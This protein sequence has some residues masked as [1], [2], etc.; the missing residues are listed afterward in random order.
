MK[1]LLHLLVVLMMG[2][3]YAQSNL[4]ACQ[5]SDVSKWTNCFGTETFTDSSKYVGD[6]KNGK[7]N[8]Q[9]THTY[10]DGSK[11]V[12]NWKDDKKHGRGTLTFSD[13]D[14]YVGNWKDGNRNGRGTLTY[15]NGNKYV[16]NWK[17]DNRNGRGTE[18]YA[19]GTKYV[20]NWKDDKKHGRGTLTFA[21][22]NKYIGE[23]KDDE[24][25]GQGTITIFD[26]DKYIGEFKDG[27]RYG[28]GTVIFA[29]GDKYFEDINDIP[30]NAISQLYG[31]KTD[32]DKDV[33]LQYEEAIN[34]F[35]E[36]RLEI[37]S[38]KGFNILLKSYKPFLFVINHKNPE[39][40]AISDAWYRKTIIAR[41]SGN[42][43]SGVSVK[44]IN[45]YLSLNGRDSTWCYANALT[46][47]S[48]TSIE[49]SI[50]SEID[51]DMWWGED[52]PSFQASGVFTGRGKQNAIVGI[53]EDCNGRQGSFI[54]ITDRSQP[55][56]IVFIK[57]L[58]G[59][60]IF[61]KLIKSKVGD[62]LVIYTCLGCGEWYELSYDVKRKRFYW[63]GDD[64]N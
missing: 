49:E 28:Q 17:D 29:N 8:G 34:R 43:V 45:V 32:D 41:P 62:S 47:T 54:L 23:F 36:E 42:I 16:G 26:G 44:D 37:E 1:Y 24:Q 18:T 40:S 30:L 60:A 64:S 2:S 20:G 19:N 56:K 9:G 21:N 38:K 27:K 31:K 10:A 5:G 14:K 33:K 3:A 48:F 55:K 35:V 53:F 52:S 11:Y 51:E 4:P 58:H 7:S 61:L 57:E 63:Y 59:F 22:G 25:N 15:A 39:L 13:G 6:F 50:R 12:G 46:R